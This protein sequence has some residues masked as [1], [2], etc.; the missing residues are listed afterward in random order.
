[1]TAKRDVVGVVFHI[2]HRVGE[3]VITSLQALLYCFKPPFR[4]GLLLQQMD[5][6]GPGSVFII[7]LTGVFSGAV[8]TLQSMYMFSKFNMETMVGATVALA[9]TRELSPVLAS[10]MI[11]GRAGSA[12]ATELGTMRVTEQIDALSAMAVNPVQYLFVPRFLASVLMFPALAMVFNVVG[13]LGS[14]LVAVRMWG[15]DPGNFIY[16]ITWYVTGND[17]VSGLVKASVFG[18]FISLVSCFM[19]YR[20]EGGAR[21]VGTATTHAVVIG[22]VSILILDYFLTVLMF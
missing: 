18:G 9:L 13:I 2:I 8:F 7:L 10:L 12:M 16:K 3:F 15:V 5:F 21:G 20:A 6:I 22:S 11:T 1:M 19:G 17:L 14:Y 4:L